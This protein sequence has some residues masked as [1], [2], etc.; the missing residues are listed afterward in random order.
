[1]SKTVILELSGAAFRPLGDGVYQF[2][3]NPI[4]RFPEK[5]LYC[6]KPKEADVQ[7]EAG[8]IDVKGAILEYKATLQVPYCRTHSKVD[9]RN[10]RILIGCFVATFIA[11]VISLFILF[12]LAGTDNFTRFVFLSL[13]AGVIAIAIAAGGYILAKFILSRLFETFR[14]M[15]SDGLGLEVEVLSNKISFTFVNEAIAS[16]FA[17]LNGVG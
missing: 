13:V 1:M 16:E 2:T 11:S 3:G 17:T 14:D 10:K 12:G 15:G 9:K 8:G 6:G 4:I 7:I 5:C